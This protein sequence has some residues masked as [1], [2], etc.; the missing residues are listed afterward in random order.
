[1][2]TYNVAEF[3]KLLG[4][5]IS[6][7]QRWDRQK[8]LVPSRTPGNRRIYTD[9]HLAKARGFSGKSLQRKNVVY[10][11]VSSQAQK[12]DLENQVK[13]LEQFSIG[14]GIGVDEWV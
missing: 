11:R 4:V 5:S 12:P 9:E 2:N 13:M 10:V 7:L 3:A 1:M 8:K 6:T 14:L